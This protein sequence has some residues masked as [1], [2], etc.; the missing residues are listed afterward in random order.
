M[1]GS[2][3]GRK[4]NDFVWVNIYECFWS[5]LDFILRSTLISQSPQSNENL[6]WNCGELFRD[7]LVGGET[8]FGFTCVWKLFEIIAIEGIKMDLKSF[9]LSTGD[10][11]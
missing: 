9:G 10:S 6:Q 4:R 2:S 3:K 11:H 5:L 1:N 8:I 7:F